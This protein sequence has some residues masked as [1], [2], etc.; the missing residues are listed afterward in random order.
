[1]KY[2]GFYVSS[3]KEGRNSCL[4]ATNKMNYICKSLAA[5]G[6]NVEIISSSMV[7]SKGNFPK[8][9][10]KLADGI[11]LKLFSAYKCG[12]IF[13][14]C[15]AL[16]HATIVLFFYLLF[17]VKRGEKILVYHSLAYMRTLKW[18]RFFKR[19]QIILEVEEIY[20]D[21]MQN[22][23]HIFSRRSY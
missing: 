2:L 3:D 13:Q 23:A 15:W 19:F 11:T 6:E 4:A 10:E 20:G 21:V 8:R 16:F 5:I 17:H 18:A 14:K 9:T 1:M 7:S 12:N 22:E